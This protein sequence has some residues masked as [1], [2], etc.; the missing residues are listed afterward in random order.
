MRKLKQIS[1]RHLILTIIII[2]GGTLRYWGLGFGLPHFDHPD[3]WAVIMP[4]IRILQSGDLNPQRFDY[5][6]FY[7]YTQTLGLLFVTFLMRLSGQI[8]D[9]SV[10]P[11]Y[12]PTHLESSYPYPQI[13]QAGRVITATL[14]TVSLIPVHLV[15]EKIGSARIGLTAAFIVAIWPLH[16]INSH[17]ITTDVPL[18][19]FVT[20][21]LYFIVIAFHN[22]KI[23]HYLWVGFLL[24]VSISTKYTGAFMI[25]VFVVGH[26]ILIKEPW[27][28]FHL[29][30]TAGIAS[31]AGFTLTTPFW[32]LDW[33]NFLYW[34]NYV[35]QTYNPP[36]VTMD[37]GSGLFYLRM[38]I[39]F[40]EIIILVL[41]LIG[42]VFGFKLPRYAW[43]L[44]IGSAFFFL[45][46]SRNVIHQNRVLI[47]LTPFLGL[48]AANGWD[49]IFVQI[50]QR[51]TSLRPS[52]ARLLYLGGIL[53][54]AMPLLA[55]S[56]GHS[57]RFTQP[58]AR[59]IARI[60]LEENLP[61]GAKASA[62]FDTPV[63]E[64]EQITVD[65]VGWSILVHDE[66]W[67]VENGY[68]HLIVSSSQRYNPNLTEEQEKMYTELL[69][70]G[71]YRVIQE[72]E[73]HILSYPNHKIFVYEFVP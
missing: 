66:Q 5:G 52:S 14:G 68:S 15:G 73:G 13:F 38:L 32:F 47:P 23:K 44:G 19:F 6:S 11:L 59:D 48:L 1:G 54:I 45:L 16:V 27:R 55:K 64:R 26:L 25:V 70:E 65:R 72:I 9:I 30:V 40:P 41:A 24:G 10:L 42:M 61:D 37:G 51:W 35:T 58:S 56:I 17:F 18:T 57:W 62:D 49:L 67:Y 12:L 43:W 39:G 33:E 7:I 53:L 28:N 60:W 46:V 50:R 69:E 2:L 36:I 71:S 21:T 3:E 63:V 31:L 8:P 34:I 29:L 20:W 22:P 4:A